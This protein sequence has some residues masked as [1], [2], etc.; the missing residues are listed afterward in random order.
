MRF[1]RQFRGEFSKTRAEVEIDPKAS[2]AAPRGS[3]ESLPAR[4]PLREDC[5]RPAAAIEPFP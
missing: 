4:Y 3:V 2:D 1:G 5:F